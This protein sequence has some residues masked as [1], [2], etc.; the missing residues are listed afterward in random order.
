LTDRAWGGLASPHISGS[1]HL[2]LQFPGEMPFAVEAAT[3][4]CEPDGS[5]CFRRPCEAYR[6]K[7]SAHAAALSKSEIRYLL[8][9]SGPISRIRR[10][11]APY[12][13][14]HNDARVDSENIVMQSLDPIGNPFNRQDFGMLWLQR[15]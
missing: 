14:A 1:A 9:V 3:L 10:P 4:V 11:K 6:A 13:R 15:G 2:G 12:P 5:D 7:H 8:A